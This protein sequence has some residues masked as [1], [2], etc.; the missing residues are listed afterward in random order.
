M[1]DTFALWLAVK[2]MIPVLFQLPET[3]W[4]GEFSGIQQKEKLVEANN[5]L[6]DIIEL[7]YR[8]KYEGEYIV[9]NT[10]AH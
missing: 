10:P 4:D 3:M 9:K 6:Q 1:M 2:Q 8:V 5:R 7:L